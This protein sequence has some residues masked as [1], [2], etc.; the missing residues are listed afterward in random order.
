MPG[1]RYFHNAKAF[2]EDAYAVLKGKFSDR[3]SFDLYYDSIRTPEQKDEFL[4]V[5]CSYRFLVKHGD[6]KLSI[7]GAN[8]VIDYLTNSFKLVALFSLIESLS[9]QKHQDFYEWLVVQDSNS[10]YPISSRKDLQR[11]YEE[12]KQTFGSIRRCV[13]FFARL[14]PSQQQTLC[15]SVEFEGKPLDGIKKVALHLYELRSKFVHEAELV[16][17]LGRPMHHITQKGYFYVNLSVP[18]LLDAFESGVVAYF[19]E[20]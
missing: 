11:L 3:N 17:Q 7:D 9:D 1:G 2:K 4:R 12:Y 10:I 20:A 18:A 16:L 15:K 19:G 13:H 14:N 6:W 5:A 8:E